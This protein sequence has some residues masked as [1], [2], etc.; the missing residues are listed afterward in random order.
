MRGRKHLVKLTIEPDGKVKVLRAT[1]MDVVLLHPDT[2]SAENLTPRAQV[3]L[4]MKN[5]KVRSKELPPNTKVEIVQQ[6]VVETKED[7]SDGE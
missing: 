3:I 1:G 4:E 5:G 7:E 2:G 6:E